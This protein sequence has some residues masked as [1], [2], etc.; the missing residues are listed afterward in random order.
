VRQVEQVGLPAP[1]LSHHERSGHA[2]NDS[3]ESFNGQ[4]SIDDLVHVR[5][6]RVFEATKAR[7]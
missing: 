2:R 7:S 4:Y 6:I 1:A 5:T 3:V